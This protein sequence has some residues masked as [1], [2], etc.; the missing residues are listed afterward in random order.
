M[1]KQVSD[2]SV[3]ASFDSERLGT[4]A[5]DLSSASRAKDVVG[6]LSTLL[7]GSDVPREARDDS[8]YITVVARL[9][10]AIDEAFYK[11]LDTQ[12]ALARQADEGVGYPLKQ[13]NGDE[14][15]ISQA[16]LRLLCQQEGLD[17]QSM[18]NVG[19]G[20]AESYRGWRRGKQPGTVRVNGMKILGV[21]YV[22]PRPYDDGD[23]TPWGDKRLLHVSK[24]HP[25]QERVKPYEAPPTWTPTK[26]GN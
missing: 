20:L 3:E 13:P 8:F 18:V 5:L 26:E 4:A 24:L 23:T 6:M 14:L 15:L 16:N 25:S 9:A 11:Q 17:F 2:K 10:Q 22:A 21:P 19:A 1:G 7:R 12:Q